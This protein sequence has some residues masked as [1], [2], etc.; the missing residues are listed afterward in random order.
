MR[1]V[2]MS[3]VPYQWQAFQA[4]YPNILKDVPTPGR[5]IKWKELESPVVPPFF[6]DSR[7]RDLLWAHRPRWANVT[8][9]ERGEEVIAQDN[10]PVGV[11]PTVL[12]PWSQVFRSRGGIQWVLLVTAVVLMIAAGVMF[13]LFTEAFWYSAF[14]GMTTI[15]FYHTTLFLLMRIADYFELHPA[16]F[17]ARCFPEIQFVGR[18]R[19]VDGDGEGPYFSASGRWRH[20]RR[21]RLAIPVLW[22]SLGGYLLSI[23]IYFGSSTVGAIGFFFVV[24]I[25]ILAILQSLLLNYSPL[26]PLDAGNR[27]MPLTFSIMMGQLQIFHFLFIGIGGALL[28]SQTLIPAGVF[29]VILGGGLTLAELVP[30]FFSENFL[31]VQRPHR[32]HRSW[33][34]WLGM[35]VLLYCLWYYFIYSDG[36][37]IAA[38][39]VGPILALVF[40]RA[41]ATPERN[42]NADDPV[43][44]PV[45]DLEE[46]GDHAEAA[47][48]QVETELVEVVVDDEPEIVV[49]ADG[50]S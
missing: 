37:A 8:E 26:P 9:T 28:Y 10:E 22:L 25:L 31:A 2:K 13:D 33:T 30:R 50:P 23:S 19:N 17:A 27:P 15:L 24:P 35:V 40:W 34:F 20:R 42:A 43:A 32:V 38:V 44:D 46:G 11:P 14:L 45:A 3:I 49:R 18:R 5:R 1:D 12:I 36:Q 29:L 16:S 6:G 39:I 21:H 4:A 47:V 48:G 7:E 41:A